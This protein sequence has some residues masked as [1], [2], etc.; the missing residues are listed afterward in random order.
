MAAVGVHPSV[1]LVED[2]E[3]EGALERR[4]ANFGYQVFTA[5]GRDEALS[6]VAEVDPDLVLLEVTAPGNGDCETLRR[7]R[8]R[9]EAPV[10]M[11]SAAA[12]EEDRV[13]GLLAGADDY[14]GKAVSP[15][16]ITARVAAVLRRSPKRRDDVFDDGV[17]VI[18]AANAHVTVR[19]EPV[20]LTPLELRLLTALTEAPGR[21]LSPE[22]LGHLVWGRLSPSTADN[23]RLYVSYLRAKIERD[24]ARPELIETVRGRGYRYTGPLL[25]A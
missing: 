15:A 14:L 2:G 8:S 18:D 7:I 20:S 21:V 23:A 16:E 6:V 13:R 1:L 24:P 12:S 19:G 5:S 22:Q 3:I 11:L 4:L 10:I 17:V 25:G 9:T